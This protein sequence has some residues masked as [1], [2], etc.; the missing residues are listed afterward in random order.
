M[1][2]WLFCLLWLGVVVSSTPAWTRD[3][4]NDPKVVAAATLKRDYGRCHVH[5]DIDACYDAVRYNPN[6]PLLL[7]ALGDALLRAQRPADAIRNYR[8][9]A[10]LAPNMRAIPAKISTAD[11]LLHPR[12]VQSKRRVDGTAVADAPGQ[13]SNAASDSQSH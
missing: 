9:A 5:A 8:R 10:I 13:Y 2:G 4:G 3:A 6:D 11:A 7:V 1:R 12:R